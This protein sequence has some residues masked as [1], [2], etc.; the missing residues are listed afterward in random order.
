MRVPAGL[1]EALRRARVP[2]RRIERRT[3]GRRPRGVV[4]LAVF[5]ALIFGRLFRPVL[6]EAAREAEVKAKAKAK[7]EKAAAEAKAKA[8]AEAEAAAAK[9]KASKLAALEK[10]AQE[11]KEAAERNLRD[12][13]ELQELNLRKVFAEEMSATRAA[14]AAEKSDALVCAANDK[15][16]LSDANLDRLGFTKYQ[17]SGDNTWDKTAGSGPDSITRD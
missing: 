8:D 17:R 7:A 4:D 5:I 3:K 13:L 15:S 12:K 11:F 9:A 2:S 1:V 10:Q 14:A 6:A 16:K